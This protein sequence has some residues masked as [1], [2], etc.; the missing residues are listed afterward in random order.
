MDT[1]GWID[2]RKKLPQLAVPLFTRC[3]KN[4]PGNPAYSYHLGLA[5]AGARNAELVKA[6]FTRAPALKP[7]ATTEAAIRRNLSDGAAAGHKQ[8]K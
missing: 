1:L 7:D 3:E 6:A 8:G 2:Y 4:A 5:H